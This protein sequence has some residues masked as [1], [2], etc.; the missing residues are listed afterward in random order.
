MGFGVPA[1]HYPD[2]LVYSRTAATVR[3][4]DQAW[5]RTFE[6][7]EGGGDATR[8][9]YAWFPIAS[10]GQIE[11]TY[12]VDASGLS[13]DVRPIWL[14]PGYVEVGIL[15]EGSAAFNDFAD[16]S[17]KRIGTAFGPWVEVQGPWARLRSGSLG[18]EW[19]LPQ[20]SGAQ[21]HAGREFKPPD[22]NWAGLDYTFAAPFSGATYRITL[23]EAQ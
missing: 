8:S 5:R 4:S 9:G 12:G 13:I 6:L 11:V 19:S 1:V 16:Q 14:K 3:I 7:D 21:L 22:F 15:N 23:Q 10:R 20:L 17:Q 18:I 2:G